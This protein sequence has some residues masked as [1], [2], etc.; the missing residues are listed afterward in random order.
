MVFGDTFRVYAEFAEIAGL[1]TGAKVRVAGMDAGQIEQITVPVS[2]SGKFRVR[3]RV[4]ND[5]HP[6]IRLDSV[7][8]IQNDG[9]V[10]NKYVQIE[11]GTEGSPIVPDQGTIRSREP[12]EFTDL[13]QKMSAT[14]DTVNTTIVSLKAEVDNA[15]GSITDTVASA[16]TLIDD[17]GVEAGAIL[18][19]SR[20]V[21]ADLQTIVAGVKEGRGTVG[22]FVTDDTL[23]QNVQKIS[24]DAQ[25]AVADLRTA[26]AQAKDAIAEVR[27]EGAPIK[28]MANNLAETL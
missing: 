6:I 16:R 13:L 4:R 11:A 28:G 27:G 2:P 26:A 1:E 10:G 21:S 23:F 18:V 12:L 9:L 25:R 19:S 24:A 5:L 8:A 20:K 15:L 14:I 17:V 22:K 7:A 3:M